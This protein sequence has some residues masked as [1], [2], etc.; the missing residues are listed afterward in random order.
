MVFTTWIVLNFY[1]PA[2][3]EITKSYQEHRAIAIC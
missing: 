2:P 1:T 3:M